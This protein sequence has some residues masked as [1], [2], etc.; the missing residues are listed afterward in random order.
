MS[1]KSHG[2]VS[3][4]ISGSLSFPL[5]EY[6]NDSITSNSIQVLAWSQT[7][8]T[9]VV[10][11]DR[12]K[13][14]TTSDFVAARI[15]SRLHKAHICQTTKGNCYRIRLFGIRRCCWTIQWH[16]SLFALL[17]HF[18]SHIF[19]KLNEDQSNQSNVYCTRV[20]YPRSYLLSAECI[21]CWLV[22]TFRKKGVKT[23]IGL[24]IVWGVGA[25]KEKNR[26]R[27]KTQRVRSRLLTRIVD[28]FIE[29]IPAS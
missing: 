5:Q 17:W 2:I 28:Y 3:N 24:I 26:G 16:N 7:H 25:D 29:W 20:W 10:V 1:V 19:A 15:I 8:V 18:F 4:H 13:F 6:R 23:G 14:R 22:Y 21:L 12:P 9:T 11:T 27:M